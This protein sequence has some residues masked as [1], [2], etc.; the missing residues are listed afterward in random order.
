MEKETI[1]MMSQSLWIWL[2]RACPQQAF[3]TVATQPSGQANTTAPFKTEDLSNADPPLRA[4]E[5]G[6][7][8]AKPDTGSAL[9]GWRTQC[10]H[11]HCDR[12]RRSFIFRSRP[13]APDKAQ[14]SPQVPPQ[15][16]VTNMV[17]GVIYCPHAH[18]R[19]FPRAGGSGSVAFFL[20]AVGRNKQL[21]EF[22]PF[23]KKRDALQCWA[24][25][26]CG[27][28]RACSVFRP[29]VNDYQTGMTHQCFLSPTFL[30]KASADQKR[31]LGG[32][33]QK[34]PGFRNQSWNLGI[35]MWLRQQDSY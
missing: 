16:C 1:C 15:V 11:L 26:W 28:E 24:S 34:P 35:I 18:Q 2:W 3:V 20:L 4:A 10:Q 7:E 33:Q 21:Q 31:P 17:W 29:T 14:N 13:P 19:P 23:H 8:T 30:N 9:G 6:C 25:L 27:E 22:T 12:T 32:S 5:T